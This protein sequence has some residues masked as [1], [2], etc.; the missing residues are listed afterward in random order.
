MIN[1]LVYLET[2]V[3]N[4]GPGPSPISSFLIQSS[5]FAG[6]LLLAFSIF[7]AF[8]SFKLPGEQFIIND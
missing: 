6:R 3:V 4:P 2:L 7:Q 5:I 1:T 8:R